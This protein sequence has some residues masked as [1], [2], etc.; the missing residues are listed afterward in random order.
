MFYDKLAVMF[1]AIES[2]GKVYGPQLQRLS[3]AGSDKVLVSGES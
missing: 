3:Y 1:E 2:L